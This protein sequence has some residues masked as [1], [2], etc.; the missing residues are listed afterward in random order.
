MVLDKINA[1][2]FLQSG[3]TILPFH[4]FKFVLH[5]HPKNPLPSEDLV[6]LTSCHSFPSDSL[7]LFPSEQRVRLI[8]T[9]SD[10]RIT[11]NHDVKECQPLESGLGHSAVRE[12]NTPFHI[13]D[14]SWRIS[15]IHRR[16]PN[17][18]SHS[19]APNELGSS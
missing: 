3:T 15:L 1:H 11:S 18:P 4:N 6:D 17:L 19:L 10:P 7:N 14:I 5:G 12:F 13:V 9:D 2:R 8:S 16:N